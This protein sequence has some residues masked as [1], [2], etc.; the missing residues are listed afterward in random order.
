[1]LQGGISMKLLLTGNIG[2][3]TAEFIE[4]SFPECEILLLGETPLRSD[5]R[6]KITV[7]SMPQSDEELKDIFITY[8]FEGV[9]YFSNY[10]T[11]HGTM[12]GEIENLRRLLR[13]YRGNLNTRFLYI[14]GPESFYDKTTGKTLMVHSAE[15]FCPPGT[16]QA[17]A[18]RRG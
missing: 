13:Y 14:T 17:A 12:D 4:Q 11:F 7:H 2:Y 15:E 5:H 6:K 8:E 9:I 3:I 16:G 10:L 1:M 18:W